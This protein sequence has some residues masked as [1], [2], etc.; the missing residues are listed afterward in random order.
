MKHYTQADICAMD[1]HYRRNFVNT[2]AGFK[3]ANL[4]GT[5]SPDGHENVAIFNSVIHLGADPP[6][7]GCLF[8]PLTVE[9]HT[10]DYLK[11]TGYYTFNQI[12]T[13]MVEAAHQTSAKYATG[14]SE[15]TYTGLTP[16]YSATH[17]APYVAE[18]TLKI[19]LRYKEEY[20][21]AANGT[22]L[23]I[24]EVVEVI[25]PEN[26]QAVSEDGFLRHEVLQSVAISG[27]D[28]YYAP[29]LLNRFSYARPH[30]VL[31]PL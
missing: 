26:L 6:L 11:A 22:V 27:L 28:G 31:K 30:K 13:D 21:L 24:G 5:K 25:L 17:P 10:Y 7:M 29:Q 20:T 15:F 23:V 4:V 1:A 8:R 14:E 9:R 12:H 16:Y 2:L 18:S 3:S 19:G